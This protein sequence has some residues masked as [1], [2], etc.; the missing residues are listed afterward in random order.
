[1]TRELAIECVNKFLD[2]NGYLGERT[3]LCVD[4]YSKCFEVQMLS[5]YGLFIV[6]LDGSVID[7]Y[8]VFKR[9]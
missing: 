7:N 1:M 5:P 9:G 8:D 4:Q 6:R 3:I 2:S